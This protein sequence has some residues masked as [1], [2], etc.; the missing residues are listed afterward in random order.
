MTRGRPGSPGHC[1]GRARPVTQSPAVQLPLTGQR[2]LPAHGKHGGHEHSEPGKGRW[3]RRA[4][5]TGPAVSGVLIAPALV[6]ERGPARTGWWPAWP[7]GSEAG[8]S[9]ATVSRVINGQVLVSPATW[10]MV[11]PAAP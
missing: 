11:R 6:G 4:P 7:R 10:Q 2:F 8:V 9:I 1:L 5:R 3:V